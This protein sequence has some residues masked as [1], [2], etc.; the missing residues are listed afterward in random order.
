MGASTY[1]CNT[2]QIQTPE[3][4]QTFAQT[5]PQRIFIIEMVQLFRRKW[6]RTC[7]FF[8]TQWP[9]ISFEKEVYS[10]MMIQHP[11][12]AQG[13]IQQRSTLGAIQWRP[14]SSK[15]SL[16]LVIS[17]VLSNY[18]ITKLHFSKQGNLNNRHL[19]SGL[20]EVHIQIIRYSDARFLQLIGQENSIQIICYS[21]H[22]LNK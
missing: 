14:N 1:V 2:D 6:K 11:D 16:T 5:G 17:Q 3:G 9:L 19:N 7:P 10:S 8:A 15:A 4:D 12:P 22:H 18:I 21:D 13:T 20:L